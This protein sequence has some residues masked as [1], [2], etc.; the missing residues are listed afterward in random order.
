MRA[1]IDTSE[2]HALAAH[3]TGYAAAVPARAR[4][5]V[6]AGAQQLVGVA[7]VLAPFEFGVLRASI[8]ADVD[9][10]SFEVGPTVEYGLYQELGT[11]EMSAQPYLGPGF[12]RTLP[13]IVT[14][15]GQI[16]DGIA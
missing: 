6:A 9:D 2:I 1:S 16:G 12:D 5:V 15:V 3:Q 7:Q 8:G 13:G 10:L 14:A 4:T 11:S